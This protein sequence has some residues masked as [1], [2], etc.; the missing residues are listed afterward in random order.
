[1]QEARRVGAVTGRR[2]QHGEGGAPGRRPSRRE[3]PR[4]GGL[5]AVQETL[6]FHRVRE[7]VAGCSLGVEL[8]AER[9]L[10]LRKGGGRCD[11]SRE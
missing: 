11:P 3:E 4:G 6:P 5:C 9:A 2:T 7:A 8:G 1:M 10:I